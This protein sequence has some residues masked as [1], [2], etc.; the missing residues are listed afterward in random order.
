MLDTGYAKIL[1]KNG[2][3]VVVDSGDVCGDCGRSGARNGIQDKLFCIGMVGGAS[4]DVA[5]SGVF[6]TKICI[7]GSGGAGGDAARVFSGGE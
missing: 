7:G 4:G 2:A 1:A 3:S 5:G 6:E